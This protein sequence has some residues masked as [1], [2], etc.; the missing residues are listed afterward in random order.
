MLGKRLLLRGVLARLIAPALLGLCLAVPAS[1]AANG[2]PASDALLQ[3]KIYFPAQQVGVPEADALN[4]IVDTANANGYAIRVA[5]ISDLSDLGTVP[6]LLDKPQQYADFLGPEIRFAYKGDLLVVTPNG[7]G[8][9]TTDV[10]QPPKQAIAGMQVEAGGTPNGLAQ[11]AGE[12]VTRL[13]KAAGHPIAGQTKGGGGGGALVGI[14]VA[15][16]LLALGVGGAYW[17]RRTAPRPAAGA[18]ASPPDPP[19]AP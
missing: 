6:N 12:A 15:V 7:L 17:V 1:A 8:L 11:T 3:S 4:K 9:T 18:P 14:L 19:P 13:A 2:D 16:A 10:T 5:L